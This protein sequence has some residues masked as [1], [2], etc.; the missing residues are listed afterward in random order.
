M[1]A[2][3][4]VVVVVPGILGSTLIKDDNPDDEIWGLTRGT[5]STAL[6]TLG[7]SLKDLRL[8]DGIGDGP[9]DDGVTAYALM[10][11]LHL[12]PGIWTHNLGYDKIL[13]WFRHNFHVVEPDRDGQTIPNLLTFP[14]DWR[15]SNRYNA[16]LLKAF[17]EPALQRWQGQGGNCAD[18]KL[19]FVCHSMG[20]LVTRWYLSQLDGLQHTRRMVTFG[21]PFRGSVNALDQLV[22]GVK[23]GWGP[24]KVDLTTM[25]RSC[26]S[27]YQLLPEYECL[28]VTGGLAKTTEFEL[29]MLDEGR[30]ED[31]MAFHET[32]NEGP[33]LDHLLYPFVGYGQP[34]SLTARLDNDDLVPIQAFKGEDSSGDGTVPRFSAAPKNLELNDPAISPFAE[35]HGT[36]QHKESIFDQLEGILRAPRHEKPRGR[37]SLLQTDPAGIGLRV[38]TA[39]LETEPVEIELSGTKERLQVRIGNEY[40]TKV[41][42]PIDVPRA[43]SRGD[44]TIELPKLEPGA[45]TV[46]VRS[47]EDQPVAKGSAQTAFYVWDEEST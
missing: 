34:T 40:G 19:V 36:L 33:S 31:A 9:A 28:E 5:V 25:A 16:G 10:P 46:T 35:G 1:H 32:M 23:K 27:I 44:R 37:Q 7:G 6:R 26:P 45:Y 18:A 42:D 17:V 43:R 29:P 15:L 4:D 13:D 22:N 11:D 41:C 2:L 30:I 12:V 24:F 14:Y 38:P 8:R 39:V 21:T 3:N 20:G 47:D